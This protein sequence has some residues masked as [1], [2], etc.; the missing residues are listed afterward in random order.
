MSE[1]DRF[2]THL[3]RLCRRLLFGFLRR[4]NETIAYL[5]F[6]VPEF[7]HLWEPALCHSRSTHLWELEL[8]ALRQDYTLV[9]ICNTFAIYV[10]QS[11]V[12][13]LS[14][15]ETKLRSQSATLSLF[16]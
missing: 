9:G 13:V 15:F 2:V 3:L 16:L 6:C 1:L 10:Q 8:A 11:K 7:T 5:L 14:V 12:F 4:E